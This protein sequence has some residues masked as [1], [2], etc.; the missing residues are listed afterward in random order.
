MRGDGYLT[1]DTAVIKRGPIHESHQL[2]FHWDVFNLTNTPKFDTASLS[3]FPDISSSFGKY[4]STLATCD[5][6]AGRCMQFGFR[7]EF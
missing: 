2:V 4:Q 7:Y 6:A 1:I 5:G 3:A